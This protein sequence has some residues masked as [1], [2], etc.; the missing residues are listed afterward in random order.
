MRCRD[1]L[2]NLPVGPILDS[3]DLKEKEVIA[4]LIAAAEMINI[5]P[6]SEKTVR[7]A[8]DWL[9][10]DYDG[11]A[12]TDKADETSIII[13]DLED[14][15]STA[16]PPYCMFT[17]PNVEHRSWGVWP[18]NGS[19]QMAEADGDL[20]RTGTVI[21]NREWKKLGLELPDYNLV[22]NDHGNMTLYEKRRAG[23]GYRW[24]EVWS[25]V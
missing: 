16:V 18:S 12:D 9:E 1:K 7:S 23:R 21:D 25:I 24:K 15:L 14:V 11:L 2:K 19:I 8:K 22:V 17:G 5:S 4:A 10:N 6:L 20:A 13:T 3:K